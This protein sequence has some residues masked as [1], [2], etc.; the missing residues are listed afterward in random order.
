MA[1]DV[2]LIGMPEGQNDLQQPD[3]PK[4]QDRFSYEEDMLN[5]LQCVN[6]D[7]SGDWTPSHIHIMSIETSLEDHF[8]K[9]WNV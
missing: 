3:A 1:D 7:F 5:G 8:A 9:F 2:E 4:E 6:E